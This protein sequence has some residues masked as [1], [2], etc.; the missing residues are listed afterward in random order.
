MGTQKGCSEQEICKEIKSLHLS[1][2]DTLDLAR[3]TSI[4]VREAVGVIVGASPTH[5]TSAEEKQPKTSG[6]VGEMYGGLELIRGSMRIIQEEIGR[7]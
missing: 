5:P 2:G 4:I 1:I 7:L 3:G 6:L